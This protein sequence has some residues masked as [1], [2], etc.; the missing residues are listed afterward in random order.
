MITGH[1]VNFMNPIYQLG[2]IEGI[3]AWI[4]NH[5]HCFVWDAIIHP[6]SNFTGGLTKPLVKLDHELVIASHYYTLM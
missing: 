2:F 3:R 6:W 4:N 1:L 5:P